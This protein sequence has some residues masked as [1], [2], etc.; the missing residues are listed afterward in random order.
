MNSVNGT[1]RVLGIAFLLQAITSLAS[2]MIMKVGLIVPGSISE[3]MLN[4]ANSPWLM[5]TSILGDTITA[6]GI[7]FLGAIMFAV[8]RKQNEEMALVGLGFYALEG[9]LLAASR[10]PGF[11]LMQISREYVTSGRPAFLEAMGSV[12]LGS[13]SFGY[14]LAMVP[15]GLGAILFYWLLYETR[16]IPRILS[17]WGLATVP[18]VLGGTVATVLGFQVPFAVY[19]PYVPFEFVVGIWILVKGLA[20]RQEQPTRDLRMA[21]G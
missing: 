20:E 17:L 19:F 21:T 4:I 13:A 1:S 11:A 15:F 6:A 2:G 7:I 8:L 9:A 3:S 16:V 12:A 18:V 10:I 14:T 5:R